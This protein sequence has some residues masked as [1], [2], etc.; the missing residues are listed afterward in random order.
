[1]TKFFSS[2]T[3]IYR[4]GGLKASRRYVCPGFRQETGAYETIKD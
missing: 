4:A 2:R 3:T 1:M